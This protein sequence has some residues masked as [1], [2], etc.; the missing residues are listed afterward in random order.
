MIIHSVIWG[1]VYK[2]I[3]D[4]AYIKVK[5]ELHA[6]TDHIRMQLDHIRDTRMYK[7]K[8]CRVCDGWRLVLYSVSLIDHTTSCFTWAC[9]YC[10]NL[11]KVELI[12]NT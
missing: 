3:H 7:Y 5:Q 8:K 12:Y 2:Y 10:Y 11:H 6:D 4:D 9:Y 1:I